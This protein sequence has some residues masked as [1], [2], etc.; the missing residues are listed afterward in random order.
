MPARYHATTAPLMA[1]DSA[2]RKPASSSFFLAGWAL[3]ALTGGLVA[4]AAAEELRPDPS[5]GSQVELQQRL[6]ADI[7][8]LASDELAGRD[9][10]TEGL[11]LAARHIA[12][13]F[14]QSGL[15][16]ELFDGEPFQTFRIAVGVDVGDR[17]RNRLSIELEG[18]PDGASDG[19]TLSAALDQDFRPMA[20]GASGAVAGPLR[21][22]GYGI[23]APEHDYDDYD[24]I[25]VE[26]AIVLMIRKEPTG[27]R[28]DAVF[29]SDNSRHAYFE[30]KMRAAAARGAAAVLLVNDPASIAAETEKIERRIAA[31]RERIDLFS[32][33]LEELPEQAG[34]VRQRL[35]RRRADIETM[36][37]GLQRGLAAGGEG[38][39]AVD[40]AGSKPI[41]ESLPVVSISWSLASR[42]VE[43]A[44]G[45]SLQQVKDEIDRDVT[46]RSFD[47]RSS[48][49]LETDLSPARVPSSNVIG[50]LPGRGSLADST[51]VLGAHYDHIG[52]GGRGSLAPGTVAIHNGADDNASGTSVLLA[53]VDLVAASLADISDHRRVV[54]IAFTGE[55]RGLL[56]SEHYVRN[57][58]FPL[59]QTVAMVNLDM[60]GRL[61][62]NDLTVYGT[63]TAAE[64]DSLVERANQQTEFSLYKVP[65]GYGPS[66]HQS[67]YNRNIPVLFFFT[68]LHSDYHRPTDTA[69]KINIEGMA[70]ITE[71]TATVVS[72]LA[73]SQS[74]P[75]YAAT[76]KEVK[77]RQQPRVF[78]GV[79]LRDDP[80]DAPAA[81]VSVSAVADDSPASEAGIRLG[82]RILKI[83]QVPTN[84]SA[85]VIAAVSARDADER[86]AIEL[87]RD[88]EPLQV[89][90]TLRLRRT[91]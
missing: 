82:D 45:K 6:A 40:Q 66:D 55:E 2:G 29:G 5:A 60:V 53:A 3:I 27:P 76:S 43:H 68:G 22:V 80:D 12:D 41:V 78:L 84:S 56:G 7:G 21:L 87:Q 83:D 81:G 50:V 16:T 13:A 85:E 49:E 42:L 1:I 19:E 20:I 35:L 62:N 61:R 38:L 91:Q 47:L 17:Q 14:R 4:V 69:D 72:E 51:V 75:S 33:Q 18:S 89:S 28:G 9:I 59:Q 79:S 70:R 30:T 67:F 31:E 52:M 8:Y 77:I 86:L 23:T 32:R 74:P 11:E 15:E 24:G 65:S 48:G 26:G 37:E 54:F 71:L 73:V 44:A 58:R 57:P 34:S 46:P 39:L 25:D 88:G 90:A 64:F 36:V 10:G 63:G